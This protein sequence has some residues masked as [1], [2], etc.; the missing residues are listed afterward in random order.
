MG[1]CVDR[2]APTC[3][4]VNPMGRFL[5]ELDPDCAPMLLEGCDAWVVRLA[6]KT[7]RL[8][9]P[10]AP[11]ERNAMSSAVSSVERIELACA[12]GADRDAALVWAAE[13]GCVETFESVF[14]GHKDD[15]G[16]LYWLAATHG[17]L[18]ALEWLHSQAAYRESWGMGS[19]GSQVWGCVDSSPWACPSLTRAGLCRQAARNGHLDV[20]EFLH[21]WAGGRLYPMLDAVDAAR[22]EGHQRIVDWAS[23][24]GYRETQPS[25]RAGYLMHV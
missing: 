14:R 15:V 23:G 20:V 6:C 25:R 22:R 10:R 16:K 8:L 21:D 5:S 4:D 19:N 13:L 3:A 1:G 2:A 7:L 11:G 9:R 17:R 24:P 12:L 18:R